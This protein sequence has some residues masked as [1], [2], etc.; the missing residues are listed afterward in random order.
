MK[1]RIFSDIHVD[2]NQKF[3]FSFKEGEKDTFTLIAGDVSGN[4]KLTA[5]WIKAN[6]TNGMFIVGNHDPCYNDLGWTIGKQRSIWL[7]SFR[8]MR[9]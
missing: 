7:R 3:P 9:Q 1:V 5:N 4:P 2:I 8:W 6:I